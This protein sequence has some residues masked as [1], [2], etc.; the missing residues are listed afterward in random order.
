MPA[1][2]MQDAGFRQSF[3]VGEESAQCTTPVQI[4]EDLQELG[5]NRAGGIRTHGLCDPNAALYQAEPQPVAELHHGALPPG[6]KRI[7]RPA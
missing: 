5:E 2:E 4:Q 1:F 3:P 6:I 7:R